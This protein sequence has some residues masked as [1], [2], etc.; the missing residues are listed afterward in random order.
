MRVWKDEVTNMQHKCFEALAMLCISPLQGQSLKVDASTHL[1]CYGFVA[2][3]VV[4]VCGPGDPFRDVKQYWRERVSPSRD[5]IV[6]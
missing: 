4:S 3:I 1:I 6:S 2:D 5:I